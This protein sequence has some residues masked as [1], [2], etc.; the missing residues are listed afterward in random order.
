MACWSARVIAPLLASPLFMAVWPAAAQEATALD[1]LTP[2]PAGDA[3]F[4][5]PTA[6]VSG[7][8]RP[9]V[10]LA[11][12]Y[13]HQ[14]LQVRSEAAPGGVMPWVE[15]QV[16]LHA[17]VSVELWR[18]LKLDLDA[19]FTLEQGGTSGSLGG[20]RLTAPSGAAAADLRA[21]A[22]TVLFHQDGLLP[23]A[24]VGFSVW[25]PSG[26]ASSFSGAGSPRYAPQ[27]IVGAEHPSFLWS[28]TAGARFQEASAN[29]LT[30]SE[31]FLAA[32]A[33]ARKGPLQIGAE[34][35]LWA[36]AGE[37]SAL[38]VPGRTGAELLFT[39]RHEV[40]PLAFAMGAGPGMG[41]LPGT[42]DFRFFA[43]MGFATDVSPA[44]HG[45]ADA[46]H[47]PADAGHGPADIA[48][49]RADAATAASDAGLSRGRPSAM[50]VSEPDLDG[51]SVPDADDECPRVIG[52]VRAPAA[53]GPRRV[54]RKGCPPDQ[55][56]DGIYDVD[57]RCPE[58]PGESNT[59]AEKNG[60]PADTDGDGVPNLADACPYERG[61]PNEDRSA[62]GCPFAVRIRGSQIVILQQVQF[63]SGKAEIQPES[64]EVLAEVAAVLEEHPEIA[65]VAVDGHTDNMGP[66]DQ[67][68]LLSQRRALA[69]VAWLT[70][71]GID[72]R[73]LEARG[74]GPRRP[75]ADNRTREGRAQNRRVEFLIRRRTD[76]GAQGWRDGPL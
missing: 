32:G 13:A 28:A 20:V 45:P 18:R 22:R 12:S 1:R 31:V 38:A 16:V 33:G 37:A 73:R 5:V 66:E 26:G 64:F 70:A 40:G 55:D 34:L 68:V 60:C 71:Y 41:Q 59:V 58:I 11:L 39:A 47:G 63:P 61:K 44:G 74:F 15:R 54:F 4:S 25:L 42:P 29:S 53:G 52:E 67:N 49:P 8:V 14:P 51:D 21:G 7:G 36:A 9:A 23:A 46:E 10:G 75:I 76:E 30:G 69:V 27:V 43:A 56:D 57:D 24:S 50:P 48:H 35:S 65:R 19:P 72:A 3:L 6:D 2:A 17:S 62:N